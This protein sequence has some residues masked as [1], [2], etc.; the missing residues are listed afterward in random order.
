MVAIG[1]FISTGADAKVLFSDSFD[2]ADSYD[3]DGS[4][5]GIMDDKGSGLSAGTVYVSPYVDPINP[6]DAPDSDSTNGGGQDITDGELRLAVG[7]GTS[8]CY[9]DH[10][11][12][13]TD[14]L[15]NGGFR[16]SVDV[17]GYNQSTLGQGG[18]F[19]IGLT[20]AEADSCGD[21]W[22][23]VPDGI[24]SCDAF[25][26]VD[27]DAVADF[28]FGIRGD[29][30]LVYGGVGQ[31]NL[32]VFNGTGSKTGTISATFAVTNF[33]AGSTVAYELF[34]EE[35]SVASGSFS[36]SDDNANYILLDS[37]D[38]TAVRFDNFIVETA[39]IDE[40]DDPPD[41]SQDTPNIIMVLL[42]D[43]GWSDLGCY[44]GEA[45][46]PTIDSLAANGIRFRNFYNTSRCSTT[47]MSL[48]S[49][50]YTHQ[51]AVDPAASLPNWKPD[52]NIS[53][54]EL[55][56]TEG[57]HTYM[58]GKWHLGT[59]A[60]RTPWDRG[61]QHTYG[62]GDTGAGI[63]ENKWVNDAK[64]TS[65]NNEVI[66][67]T[68]GTEPYDY[69]Q[70]DAIVDHALDFVDHHVGKD[71][72]QSFFMYLPFYAPHFDMQ[73][74]MSM[75]TNVPAGE[76]SYLEIYTQGWDVVRSNR[77]ERMVQMGIIDP[78]K[79][80]LS[81]KG[82]CPYNWDY[83]EEIKAIPDWDSL[84]D[85]RKADLSLR[86]ALYTAMIDK[87]DQNLARLVE[88]LET[89]GLLDD[90]LILLISDNGGNAEGGMFGKSFGENNHAPLTGSQLANMGQ[91]GAGDGLWL[92]GGWANVA[93]TP[94]RYFKRYS[95]EGGIR[96]PCIAYW[97]SGITNPGRWTEQAGH[98]VDILATAADLS[99]A[100]YPS[101][102]FG[103]TVLPM[104]GGKPGSGLQGRT[105]VFDREL[106]FE[107]ESCRAF[108]DGHW[109]FVTKTLSNTDGTSP[110][111]TYEL[112][113]L[114]VD[115][116]ELNNL[117]E[118]EPEKLAELIGKWN[119]WAQHVGVAEGRWLSLDQTVPAATGSDLF[120]DTFSRSYDE[121]IDVHTNGMSGSRLAQMGAGGV[122]Y[123]GFEGSGQATSIEVLNNRLRLANGMGMAENGLMHNFVGQDIIDAGG[124]SVEMRIH[125][126]N[127]IADDSPGR[128][129]GFGI[130]MTQAEAAAGSDIA[131]ADSFRG[132]PR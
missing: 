47:R 102:Y 28:W 124:F 83:G 73:A 32:T 109:K 17:A 27:A 76:Q 40:P 43:M 10:N 113:N 46:T 59:I 11:F 42:D 94:L 64:V 18:V 44:G 100:E 54:P 5:D 75:V 126:L 3:I 77:Y 15:T 132:S 4:M 131:D 57:Y 1:L 33:S 55:L 6:V 62:F 79:Y 16:V 63:G 103:R 48:L 29:Q 82:D 85:D 125:S 120:L 24:S 112:Y 19:S 91:P 117:A 93:D 87:I 123:E 119:A 72:G 104:E 22:N 80:P 89:D 86:M 67:R 116:V 7:P 115:P 68:Y 41:P 99:N 98:L 65:E 107:H 37:R 56:R 53:I 58:A 14:I 111:D 26:G 21:P 36:W 66:E 129:V 60:G 8:C 127:T 84:S 92:G 101:S 2:R 12:I 30:S 105:G 71:D 49:G 78:L 20:K 50:L 106:G 122:Y 128:Y 51:V 130:G 13:N 52:N 74:P 69:Y 96:T 9:L 97:P 25:G 31:N 35:T 39:T 114:D 88:K 108:I 70:T 121:D 38:N 23:G 110:E 90:T 118:E 34:F 61:F 45:R 81:P 95:H